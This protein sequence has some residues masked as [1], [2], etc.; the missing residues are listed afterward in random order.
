MLA[1]SGP[2]GHSASPWLSTSATGSMSS[3]NETFG[4]TRPMYQQGFIMAAPS[5]SPRFEEQPVV[6]T[7][8]KINSS[9]ARASTLEFGKDP[10]FDS[11]YYRRDLDEDAPPTTSVNDIMN[12]TCLDVGS[13]RK[14]RALSL[15]FQHLCRRTALQGN[16]FEQ[17]IFSSTRSPLTSTAVSDDVLY[18][19]V[20]GYPPDKY[21]VA[22]EYFKQFGETTEPQPS[23]ELVNAFRI[24]YLQPADA[25]RAV[26]K[27]GEVVGGS[28]VIG[29]KWENPSRVEHVISHP[30]GT[31]GLQQGFTSSASI[32]L[33]GDMTV[34]LPVSGPL[35]HPASTNT[36]VSP[37]TAFGT[38]IRLAPSTSAFR[39]PGMPAHKPMTPRVEPMATSVTTA[40][41]QSK[42][43]LGQFS[44]LI[45]GW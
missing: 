14:V 36:S 44:D 42:G 37:P 18:V 20:F 27:N 1:S 34:D 11:S 41:T 6:K 13:S 25:M 9:L 8:A 19:V 29:A 12:S 22:V 31:S 45:F 21:P 38:P 32:A 17:S 7:K 35:S 2:Y 15:L 16:A 26:R 10:M 30:I 28:W 23:T 24:G 4:Q 43:V 33:A 39:K 5:T 3:L 40:T